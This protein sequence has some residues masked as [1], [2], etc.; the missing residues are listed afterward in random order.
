M[1]EILFNITM[2]IFCIMMARSAYKMSK[3]FI[4][5]EKK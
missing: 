5:E 4:A 3:D 1:R 2:A